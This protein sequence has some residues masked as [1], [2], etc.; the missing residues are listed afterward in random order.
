MIQADRTTRLL[1]ISAAVVAGFVDAAGFIQTGGYFVSFMTGN[2]TRLGIGLA[3]P[4]DVL[5]PAALVLAFVGGVTL[6]SLLIMARR[7]FRPSAVTFGFVAGLL[8]ISAALGGLGF[9]A[10]ATLVMAG[11]M[12]AMNAA[13]QA[14]GEVRIG[15]T[16]M[17]GTLVKIGQ[18]VAGALGGGPS[19]LWMPY[20]LQW[21]GLVAGVALGAAAY[22]KLE[23]QA[24]W[25]PAAALVAMSLFAA[26]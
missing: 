10:A 6:G 17:T 1:A 16:Y 19:W 5:L 21:L 15:L 12:G 25:L 13:F 14:N 2:S 24:L 4:G 26:K 7:S 18:R 8:A 20:L 11:A 22:G 23:T 9:A 3:G